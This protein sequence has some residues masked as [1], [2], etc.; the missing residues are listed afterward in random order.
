MLAGQQQLG[1]T[2]ATPGNRD[3]TPG[4]MLVAPLLSMAFIKR[5][6]SKKSIAKKQRRNAVMA[7]MSIITL[8]SD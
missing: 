4:C 1:H 3:G 5:H 8:V 6:V 7:Q 2:H